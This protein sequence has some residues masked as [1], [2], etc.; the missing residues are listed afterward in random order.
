MTKIG[1]MGYQYDTARKIILIFALPIFNKVIDS[2][3]SFLRNYGYLIYLI[4]KLMK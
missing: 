1:A 4:N 3:F 2:Y